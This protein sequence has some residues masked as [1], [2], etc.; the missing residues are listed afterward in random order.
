MS[1]WKETFGLAVREALAR[2]IALIQTDSG[3]T[4]EHGTVPADKLIPIGSTAAPVQA[5]I[6]DALAEHPS[7][8]A[9][10]KVTNFDDQAAALDAMISKVLT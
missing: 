7:P 8:A 9:P 1:Q 3:G 5:Q 6:E 4:T 2:G 10:Q